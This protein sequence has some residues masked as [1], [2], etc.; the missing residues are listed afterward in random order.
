MAIHWAK[1]DLVSSRIHAFT[2][3]RIF[4][5]PAFE[6]AKELSDAAAGGQILMSH[7]AWLNF[8]DD[9]PKA[10][11]P[12]VEQLG[13]YTLDTRP[14]A[15]LVYNV[16][17]Q[18]GKKLIRTFPTLRK[19]RFVMASITLLIDSSGIAG[20]QGHGHTDCSTA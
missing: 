17:Q 6:T 9:F 11:F 20:E 16:N 18:V 10:G 8:T 5:G 2:K 3:H 14:E 7:D 4:E 19:L 1:S 13:T 12:T 15:T